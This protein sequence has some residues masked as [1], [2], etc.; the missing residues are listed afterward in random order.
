ML[1]GRKWVMK[2]NMLL[3]QLSSTLSKQSLGFLHLRA[4]MVI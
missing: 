4:L 2:D 1:L 3:L